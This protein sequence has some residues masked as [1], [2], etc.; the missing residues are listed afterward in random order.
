VKTSEGGEERGIDVHK[1]TPGRKCHIAVETLGLLL[2]VFVHS[3][4]IQDGKGDFQTMQKL[5]DKIKCSIYKW[6]LPFET[7]MG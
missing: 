6:A 5:F 1:Q 7:D 3:A 2:I 4:N